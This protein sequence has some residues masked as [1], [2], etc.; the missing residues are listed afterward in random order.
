MF[1]KNYQKQKPWER[2]KLLK[3]TKIELKNSGLPDKHYKTL[4]W[5]WGVGYKAVFKEVPVL[6]WLS[7]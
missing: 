7:S 4:E 3:Q 6:Y 1:R 2:S 5:P